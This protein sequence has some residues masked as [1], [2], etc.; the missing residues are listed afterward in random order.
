VCVSFWGEWLYNKCDISD[1]THPRLF[2]KAIK[3]PQL[4][5]EPI[6]AYYIPHSSYSKI[7][8]ASNGKIQEEITGRI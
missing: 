5:V 2:L 7:K 8:I 4:V 3:Y 6:T 1:N